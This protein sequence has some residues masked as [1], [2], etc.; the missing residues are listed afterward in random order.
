MASLR[1]PP[2]LKR[3]PLGS[4][5]SLLKTLGDA[6][7][8]YAQI[9]D[10][11][12]SGFLDAIFVGLE[13]KESGGFGG[14]CLPLLMPPVLLPHSERQLSN[15]K[16]VENIISQNEEESLQRKRKPAKKK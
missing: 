11:F 12:V 9:C 4:L 5:K 13:V 16:N 2:G 10:R 15:K 8:I 3:I 1:R 14:G 7:C 6:Y